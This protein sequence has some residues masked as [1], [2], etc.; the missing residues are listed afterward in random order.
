MYSKS[1]CTVNHPV[2]LDRQTL[3]VA[4]LRISHR[5]LPGNTFRSPKNLIP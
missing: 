2:P 1:L 4:V 5:K 3:N